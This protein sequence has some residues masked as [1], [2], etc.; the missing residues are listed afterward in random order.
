VS[1]PTLDK[2]WQELTE[3][4]DEFEESHRYDSPDWETVRDATIRLAKLY[5][6]YSHSKEWKKQQKRRFHSNRVSWLAMMIRNGRL[7]EVVADANKENEI[8]EQAVL[9]LSEGRLLSIGGI[10]D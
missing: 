9:D 8:L 2:E 6:E 7:D 5:A 3:T 10:T 1:L 4:I